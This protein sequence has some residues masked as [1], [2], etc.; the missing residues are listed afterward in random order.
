[1]R[2][3][4][5]EVQSYKADNE[6]LVREYTQ[7]NSRVMQRLNQL[8]RKT[9]RG[10]NSKQEEEGMYHEIRDDHGRDGYSRSTSRARG[11]HSPPYS[12]RKFYALED[13]VSNPKVSLVKH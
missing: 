3:L 11:H 6:R 5:I 10:S 12:K 13:P 4:K 9:K 1:M 2:S 8:Q 7:I